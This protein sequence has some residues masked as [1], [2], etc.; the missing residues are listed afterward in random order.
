MKRI[1]IT[2]ATMATLSASVFAADD[3]AAL[4]LAKAKNCLS[5]HSVERK[6]VGPAFRDVAAKYKGNKDALT[7][8]A[9]KVV[10]GGSGVWG[11]VPMPANSQVN[12][13]DARKLVTW[14]LSTK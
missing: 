12:E 1:L 3:A 8:L 2:L 14:V 7:T 5:C 4:D 10:A 9:Q 13:A 11:V 6:I